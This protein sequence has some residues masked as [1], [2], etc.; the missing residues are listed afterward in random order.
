MGRKFQWVACSVR[1]FLE[2]K[3]VRLG[4]YEILDK[5]QRRRMLDY[6]T[7]EHNPPECEP[8]ARRPARARVESSPLTPRSNS[9]VPGIQTVILLSN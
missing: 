7:E 1:T 3:E 6:L 2:D 8:M 5:M 9:Q 4:N